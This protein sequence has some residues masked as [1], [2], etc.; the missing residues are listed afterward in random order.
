MNTQWRKDSFFGNGVGK[1][2]YLC[3]KNESGSVSY[4]KHMKTRRKQMGETP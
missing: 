1:T 3:V 2:E 4:I